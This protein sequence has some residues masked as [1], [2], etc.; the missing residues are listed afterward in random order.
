MLRRSSDYGR[1]RLPL[2]KIAPVEDALDE[3]FEARQA[4]STSDW[5]HRERVAAEAFIVPV[6]KTN[7]PSRLS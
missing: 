7:A 3:Y 2:R 1:V 5:I 6:G 4:S